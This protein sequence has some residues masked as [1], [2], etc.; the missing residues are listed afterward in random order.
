MRKICQNLL[1]FKLFLGFAWCLLFPL[2]SLSQFLIS[3]PRAKGKDYE[4]H[5][6]PTLHD[7]TLHAA[8]LPH[9]GLDAQF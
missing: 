3:H 7:D 9:G 4:H 6:N 5:A 2:L 8:F 1:L